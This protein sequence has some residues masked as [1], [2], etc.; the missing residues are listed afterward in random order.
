MFED[1]F[2]SA[3]L[4]EQF[5][6]SVLEKNKSKEI[7]WSEIVAVTLEILN[8]FIFSTSGCD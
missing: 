3:L 8:R 1:N 6:Y 2:S 4:P 7:F 5:N